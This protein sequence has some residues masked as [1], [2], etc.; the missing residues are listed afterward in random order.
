MREIFASIVIFLVSSVFVFADGGSYSFERDVPPEAKVRGRGQLELSGDRFKDGESSLKF[1]WMGQA[2]LLLVDPIA[3]RASMADSKNGLMM[4]ICNDK[5]LEAPIHIAFKD[6]NGSE[7]C[8][9]DVNMDFYGWRAIWVRYCDMTSGAGYYGDIPIDSRNIDG[10]MMSVRPSPT[11]ISGSFYIDRLAF[12][13]Q[14]LHNQIAPDKQ[15]PSNNHFLSRRNMWHWCRLWEWE[16]NPKPSAKP[17]DAAMKKSLDAV[18]VNIDAF[19]KDEMP[20]KS[21]YEVLK[22]R[23][24]LEEMFSQMQLERLSDGSVKGKPIVSNDE[25]SS[26]DIKMQKAFDVLYRY[27]IDYHFTSEKK[28]LERFFLVGD[29]LLWQGVA[30]GS[31]MGTNHHY[32]YNIRGWGNA[33]WLM[34]DELKKAGK[35]HDYLAAL[36]YWSGI[37]ECHAEYEKGRD[38]IIDSWNTLLLPKITAALLQPADEEKYAYM[39]G[40]TRWVSS[41]MYFTPGTIG[42][43]KVDGTT[44]HHGGHYPAYATGAYSTLG[45]YFRIVIGT[46]FEPDK[47]ALAAVK[48]GLMSMKSYCNLYDWGIGISGRHPF[49]G[50]IP[51]KAIDCFGYLALFGDQTGS[52][53]NYD[54]ELGGVYLAMKGNNKEIVSSLKKNG[55]K[56]SD[57]PEGFYVYNYG[58]FGIH[59]RKGWMITLKGFNSDV[60]GSEIYT[61]DNRFGRYQSYGSV[62]VINSGNPASA[63]SSGYS[64]EGWDW[65]RLPGTTTIHLPYDKLENPLKGTLMER[66]VSRFPGVSSLQGRNGVLAFTYTEKDRT[67]FCPGATATKSVFCFDNRIVFIGTGITNNSAYPTE[68]TLFQQKMKDKSES[69]IIDNRLLEGFPKIWA[70]DYKGTTVLEDL[71]GNCYIIRDSKNLIISKAEQISPDNTNKKTGK[72][73]FV[74]AYL[75]HG[76]APKEASYEY[77]M[78]V[79]PTSSERSKYSGELPYKVLC[80]DNSAHVVKDVPTGITAYISYKGYESDRTAIRSI[81]PETIVMEKLEPDGTILLSVCTPDLGLTE[82]SYTTSQESKKIIKEININGKLIKAECIDGQP[83]ELRINY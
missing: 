76:V 25:S 68:T 71:C 45:S 17:M 47:K 43:I 6:I 7:I 62:Q 30:F 28:S 49:G 32:G 38:E 80:A 22:F 39:E 42:G 12:S 73:N 8:G 40:L 75:N 15:I 55:I 60:W 24:K 52:G 79:E 31:G 46:G 4:W 21:D 65:N 10:A 72:G 34:R 54:P 29:H 11:I 27:A 14:K 66:N 57:V 13:T 20:S 67:N 59:R 83:C 35:I 5:P 63:E 37:A 81:P 26:S 74:A 58:A 36:E 19:Y 51:A 9:F 56:A 50:R 16:Q 44:F 23:P 69:L 33:L 61:N 18:M 48:K 82:K 77:L 1:S 64:E 3:V 78:L 53:K 41:S 70:P 2:E